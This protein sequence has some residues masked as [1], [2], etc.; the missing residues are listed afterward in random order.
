MTGLKGSDNLK[1]DFS[2][3]E[4]MAMIRNRMET[5]GQNAERR[6][7]AARRL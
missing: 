5:A 4:L 7:R 6:S 3:A 1:V 2:M